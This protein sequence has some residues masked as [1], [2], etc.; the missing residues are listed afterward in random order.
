MFSN[1][2]QNGWSTRRSSRTSIR[3]WSPLTALSDENRKP[4][5][6]LLVKLKESAEHLNTLMAKP[7]FQNMTDDLN[8]TMGDLKGWMGKGGGLDKAMKELEDTLE[9]TRKMMKGYDA[10]SLFGRKLEAMLKEVGKTSEETKRFI[11]RLNK[12][13]NA[14]IFGD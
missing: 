7:S 8:S 2:R 4:L 9:A 11:E 3:C 1:S 14:L 10:N 13:P 5:H 6:D 12:K